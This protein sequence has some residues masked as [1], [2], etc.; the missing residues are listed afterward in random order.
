MLPGNDPHGHME[1]SNSDQFRYQPGSENNSS[2]S[3]SGF[4]LFSR[5]RNQPPP[6]LQRGQ[7]PYYQS[8]NRF[9]YSYDNINSSNYNSS[10]SYSSR[11]APSQNIEKPKPS[12]IKIERP[13][14]P[15]GQTD[16]KKKSDNNNINISINR[17]SSHQ[18]KV[19]PS[20]KT[21]VRSSSDEIK[22]EPKIKVEKVSQSDS[23]GFI[24]ASGD[25]KSELCPFC[26]N[27]SLPFNELINHIITS[28]KL[29]KIFEDTF[30]SSQNQEL[31][32]KCNTK[33]N[34]NQFIKHCLEKH[35]QALFEMIRDK[36]MNQYESRRSEI[37]AFIE[38][39]EPSINPRYSRTIEI[40]SSN[41]SDDDDPALFDEDY[42]SFAASSIDTSGLA[43]QK[44]V[45][46]VK[47]KFDPSKIE[48]NKSE[49]RNEFSKDISLLAD[50]E[51]FL[52]NSN[53]FQQTTNNSFICNLCK[54]KFDSVIRLVNHSYQQHRLRI[55]PEIRRAL[56]LMKKSITYNMDE[57]D[58]LKM[59][60][61]RLDLSL[62]KVP[63]LVNAKDAVCA[64][65]LNS[66]PQPLVDMILETLSFTQPVINLYH[67]PKKFNNPSV[68]LIRLPAPLPVFLTSESP[69][70]VS[71][72]F[73]DTEFISAKEIL[74][75][76]QDT[77]NCL[78]NQKI[79]DIFFKNINADYGFTDDD[80]NE[81][82][83]DLDIQLLKSDDHINPDGTRSFSIAVMIPKW[84]KATKNDVEREFNRL[85]DEAKMFSCK[86]CHQPYNIN[87]DQAECEGPKASGLTIKVKGK[88]HEPERVI[89]EYELNEV[90]LG[91]WK[92]EERFK[93]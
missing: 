54:I 26:G 50:Y 21:V 17:T 39:H 74:S 29:L 36:C 84:S 65:I 85:F 60:G 38:K 44:K 47:P 8:N 1:R 35:H 37:E 16:I 24:I 59:P 89:S 9:N 4:N 73:I 31:C 18:I 52:R 14:T 34:E 53:L 80:L 46:P 2:S 51:I 49:V 66:V 15:I 25:A 20:N 56:C 90:E 79:F 63:S 78:F 28:H 61:L 13:N 43:V 45:I 55:S 27:I 19:E 86:K 77:L 82:V 87:N 88:K 33:I 7:R 67:T 58:L 62:R 41:S 57:K 91:Y 83:E 76:V 32:S 30:R 71:L 75:I 64:E 48:A 11:P 72:G 93:S 92:P 40:S 68:I 69:G 81:I 6:Q 5:T 10:D 23:K 22:V 3:A 12:S 42:E 70:L